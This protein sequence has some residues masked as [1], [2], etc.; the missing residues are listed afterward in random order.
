MPDRAS[1]TI[2]ASGEPVVVR[3]RESGRARRLRVVV[4]GTEPVEVV[5]PRRVSN[6]EVD[7]FLGAHRGWIEAR[8]EAERPRLGLE[9][10]GA[11]PF[12]GAFLRVERRAGGKAL[13]AVRGGALQV[14]G[15]DGP[16]AAAVER[17]YRRAARARI[18]EAAGQEAERLGLAY[19]SLAIRDGRTR[20]GSC[21][22]RGT[23]SFSWR[24]VI[25]PPDVLEY[26]VVH[27]LC[28]L[29][30]LDHSNA[31]W[32]LVEAACPAWRERAGWLRAHGGELRRYR[33]AA[34]LAQAV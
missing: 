1:R 8:L 3:V 21:S 30:R 9:R 26:V 34:A 32:R 25:A 10:P 11:V 27:E 20:W 2:L 7:R 24:L 6:A 29:R 22:P 18:E 28:H 14:T 5:V 17:W 12:A 33:P 16:A 19:S 15:E 31:F 13:A 4:G 23:L